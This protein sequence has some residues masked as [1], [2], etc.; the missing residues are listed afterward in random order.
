MKGRDLTGQTFGRL[1]VVERMPQR[2]PSRSH[3]W[4]CHCECG[5]SRVTLS[6]ALVGGKTKSCGCL[7]REGLRARSTT[8][9]GT[10]TRL[11]CIWHSMRTRCNNPNSKTYRYYGGRGIKVCV[12]WNNSFAAFASDMGASHDAHV[13]EHGERQ[14]TLDRIDND[15]NYEPGNC[16]WATRSEQVRNSRTFLHDDR[17]AETSEYA[18][19]AGFAILGIVAAVL[20]IAYFVR[21]RFTRTAGEIGAGQ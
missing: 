7:V 21:R 11:H 12:R 10:N 14:T 19:L 18:L 15:G 1:T 3:R 13:A 5:G 9:G 8:H 2:A 17:G 16:R 20:V 4:R 6:T